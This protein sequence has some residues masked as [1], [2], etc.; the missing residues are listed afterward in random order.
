MQRREVSVCHCCQNVN[1]GVHLYR[2]TRCKIFSDISKT[3][4]KTTTLKIFVS[5]RWF[6]KWAAVAL[7][8]RLVR[9][10][11]RARVSRDAISDRLATEFCSL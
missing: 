6:M 7:S 11:V 4:T 2:Q 10:C 3:K 1:V 5:I 9:L 8:F